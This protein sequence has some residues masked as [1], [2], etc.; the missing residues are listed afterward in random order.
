MNDTSTAL[1]GAIIAAS[2][3]GIAI[4]TYSIVAS[5]SAET[6]FSELY[7][8][9]EKLVFADDEGA[10]WG[11]MTA[12]M[13]DGGLLITDDTGSYGPFHQ[14]DT[15]VA[16][17]TWWCV[18]DVDPDG[19]EVV[20]RNVPSAVS[21]G[22]QFS[23]GFVIANNEGSSQ[24]YLWTATF[25]DQTSSGN[26]VIEDGA[27]RLFTET[28]AMPDIDLGELTATNTYTEVLFDHEREVVAY[29]D[30]IRSITLVRD[31]Q[32]YDHMLRLRLTVSL[33]RGYDI[34]YWVSLDDE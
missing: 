12:R 29:G 22:E 14:Q 17:G 33:E 19:G 27:S 23:F 31:G 15:F 18:E 16:H 21:E 34:H 5:P 30:D 2:L 1:Y 3:I 26:I 32:P 7:F 25:L 10:I 20:V 6:P 4:I 11:E 8:N 9:G 24:D 13:A 28:F